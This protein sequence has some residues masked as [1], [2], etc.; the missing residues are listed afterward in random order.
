MTAKNPWDLSRTFI[1][2]GGGSLCL[3]FAF[4]ALGKGCYDSSQH[5]RRLQASFR[6]EVL[7]KSTPRLMTV[8]TDGVTR[9]GI[10][11]KG[12][13]FHNTN[14]ESTLILAANHQSDCWYTTLRVTEGQ[15]NLPFLQ[16]LGGG[17]KPETMFVNQAFDN[18]GCI[19]VADATQIIGL[20]QPAT[21]AAPVP[22]PTNN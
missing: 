20:Q 4:G 22:A 11:N 12:S 10:L 2:V 16:K 8:K 9:Q 5:D 7:K 17:E 13:A 21:P 19:P 15:E 1:G 3:V 14:A 18:Y 6:E